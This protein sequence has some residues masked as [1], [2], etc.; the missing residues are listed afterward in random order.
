MLGTISQHDGPCPCVFKTFYKTTPVFGLYKAGP[1]VTTRAA[2]EGSPHPESA[3]RLL[4]PTARVRPGTGNFPR[5]WW[6]SLFS[7]YKE[8]SV[9][10]IITMIQDCPSLE[11][12]HLVPKP[13][14]KA[15]SHGVHPKVC[16]P[17]YLSPRGICTPSDPWCPS[18]KVHSK[19]F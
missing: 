18:Y 15:N 3:S 14:H 9:V 5:G 13:A 4:L 6:S 1:P 7:R 11:R 17:Q 8:I 12:Y 2:T 19:G 16:C 10:Q